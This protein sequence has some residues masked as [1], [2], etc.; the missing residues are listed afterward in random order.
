MKA[1]TKARYSPVAHSQNATVR[2]AFISSFSPIF[3][4]FYLRYIDCTIVGIAY[5]TREKLSTMAFYI[6]LSRWRKPNNSIEMFRQ[7]VVAFW[8]DHTSSSPITN[9]HLTS[10]NNT[11]K[12]FTTKRYFS[13]CK[14]PQVNKLFDCVLFSIRFRAP[15]I[16]CIWPMF[17]T[18]WV[19][20]CH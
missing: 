15:S 6:G 18:V 11:T 9:I 3:L 7:D 19:A 2:S 14:H 20:P 13:I 16:Y 1:Q 17:V 4:F 8:Q 5:A 12:L 10:A